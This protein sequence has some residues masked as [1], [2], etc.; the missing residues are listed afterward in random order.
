[1]STYWD[2]YCRDCG[3]GAGFESRNDQQLAVLVSKI[4]DWAKI[5]GLLTDLDAEVRLLCDENGALPH[6]PRFA[7]EH[8]GHDVTLRSEYG[9]FSDTCQTWTPCPTC[10]GGKLCALRR[11]HG[12]EHEIRKE[13]P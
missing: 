9:G 3:K 6:F 4:C 8:A 5:S 1:M 12:G 7:H 13:R 11:G 10:G 2:I